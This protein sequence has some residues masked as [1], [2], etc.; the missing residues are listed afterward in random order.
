MNVTAWLRRVFR[1]GVAEAMSDAVDMLRRLGPDAYDLARSNARHQRLTGLGDD[2]FGPGHWDRVRCE[3]RRR[4]GREVTASGAI[5]RRVKGFGVCPSILIAAAL[6]YA[7][8][9]DADGV[10]IQVAQDGF[11]CRDLGDMVRA[12][13]RQL[14]SDK[15]GFMAFYMAKQATGACQPLRQGTIGTLLDAHDEQGMHFACI[16]QPGD[17]ACFWALHPRFGPAP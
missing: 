14:D 10:P 9:A 3:I 5:L 11:A 13:L 2:I 1:S 16:K 4:L 12:G 6:L 17:N 7:I 8:P 15:A